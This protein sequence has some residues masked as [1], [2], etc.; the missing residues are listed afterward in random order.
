M[1][2]CMRACV[3]E[4]VCVSV[5]L[6]GRFQSNPL[7][8]CHQCGASCL[9]QLIGT[10]KCY[11]LVPGGLEEHPLYCTLHYYVLTV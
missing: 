5:S 3:C 2:V 6:L 8:L 7:V 11:M 10:L 9:L 1:C 4:C